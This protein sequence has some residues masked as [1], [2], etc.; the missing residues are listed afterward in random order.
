M[1]LRACPITEVD[2]LAM[3]DAY[4]LKLFARETYRYN[5]G[6]NTCRAKLFS[7]RPNVRKQNVIG[8]GR[9][10]S[11]LESLVSQFE[12]HDARAYTILRAP[13]EGNL[14]ARHSRPVK[15]SMYL[16]GSILPATDQFLSKTTGLSIP[17]GR[18]ILYEGVSLSVGKYVTA[19][20]VF[21]LGRKD[22]ALRL[23]PPWR[24]GEQGSSCYRREMFVRG[25]GA[26]WMKTTTRISFC[27]L[28]DQL[29]E[30]CQTLW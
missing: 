5:A 9:I 11:H 30:Q 14:P 13:E 4:S 7:I 16:D 3:H 26:Q 12:L 21:T 10:P 29:G 20:A 25:R 28:N 1:L 23:D 18:H 24:K 27:Q 2:A 6:N 19:N 22:E 15:R 8:E 17:G